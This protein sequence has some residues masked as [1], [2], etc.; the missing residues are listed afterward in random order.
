MKDPFTQKNKVF[1]GFV[2]IDYSLVLVSQILA[3]NE[4]YIYGIGATYLFSKERIRKKE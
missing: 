3:R 1:F 2:N 4:K